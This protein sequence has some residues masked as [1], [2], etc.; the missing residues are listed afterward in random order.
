MLVFT[1]AFTL[2]KFLLVLELKCFVFTF[3]NCIGS[4]QSGFKC[5]KRSVM[6]RIR[7][8]T[9]CKGHS[10]LWPSKFILSI[11]WDVVPHGWLWVV[12]WMGY[13]NIYIYI[14]TLFC[15]ELLIKACSHTRRCFWYTKVCFC[16][17]KAACC[18]DT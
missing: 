1:N 10:C 2:N 14:Y 11:T 8:S 9:T 4:C 6:C 12:M 3:K 5:M 17:W 18:K 13:K 15:K 7:V 16:H